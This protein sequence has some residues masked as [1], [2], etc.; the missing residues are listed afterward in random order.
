MKQCKDD[1]RLVQLAEYITRTGVRIQEVADRIGVTNRTI[2]NWLGNPN[3]RVSPLASRR[4]NLYI[5]KILA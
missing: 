1:L 4:L 3:S 2:Y 5:R